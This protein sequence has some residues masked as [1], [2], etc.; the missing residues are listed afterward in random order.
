MLLFPPQLWPD[1]SYIIGTSPILNVY[2]E[3]LIGDVIYT[4]R[5]IYVFV[6]MG[7]T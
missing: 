1:T 6:S 3:L 5:K 4:V 2:V 7:L